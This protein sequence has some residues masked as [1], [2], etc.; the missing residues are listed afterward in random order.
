MPVGP[1]SA[2]LKDAQHK[3]QAF[4]GLAHMYAKDYE[5]WLA[6]HA[7]FAA[8]LS[9]AQAALLESNLDPTGLNDAVAQSLDYSQIDPVQPH[10]SALQARDAI[11]RVMPDDVRN[12]WRERLTSL[13]YLDNQPPATPRGILDISA[14][15]LNGSDIDSYLVSKRQEQDAFRHDAI[16]AWDEG[17]A[18]GA[19][20]GTYGADLAGFEA[21]LV[22]RSRLIGDDNLVQ[23]EL[24][25]TLACA[26]LEQITDMP[27][28]YD[29]AVAMVRSRLAWAV[30]PLESASLASVLDG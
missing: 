4:S 11:S 21:W 24:L 20:E 1:F 6:L 18:W 19:I 3:S 5:T 17:N 13:D 23:T 14:E 15:R 30:G 29:S 10:L 25:W 16:T 26:A 22:Q 9:A 7:Q 28:D 2:L 12:H 27:E 8:D